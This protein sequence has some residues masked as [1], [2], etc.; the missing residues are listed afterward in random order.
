MFKVGDTVELKSS[1]SNPKTFGVV[2]SLTP[3][4]DRGFT[5]CNASSIRIDR[6]NI[7]V[8]WDSSCVKRRKIWDRYWRN[9]PG[10]RAGFPN[11]EILSRDS[12]ELV[13]ARHNNLCREMKR[14]LK[15]RRGPKISFKALLEA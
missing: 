2:V 7:A 6:E 12:V 9:S 14:L 10:Y 13:K 3:Y 4:W 1:R 5:Y 15:G 11:T 8:T